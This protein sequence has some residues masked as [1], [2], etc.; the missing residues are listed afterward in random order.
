MQK[1]RKAGRS[2]AAR[3]QPCHGGEALNA[4]RREGEVPSLDMAASLGRS[5]LRSH[6]FPRS[7]GMGR[8]GRCGAEARTEAGQGQNQAVGQVLLGMPDPGEFE[9]GFVE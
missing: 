9:N 4:C 3:I 1:L 8:A 6:A 5:G 7:I 2:L